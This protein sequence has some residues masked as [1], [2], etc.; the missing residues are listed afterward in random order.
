MID[1]SQSCQVDVWKAYVSSLW[2]KHQAKKEEVR[3]LRAQRRTHMPQFILSCAEQ[4]G[5]QKKKKV[6]NKN[7]PRRSLKFTHFRET[8][9]E[10]CQISC[11]GC[12]SEWS[13]LMVLSRGALE[14]GYISRLLFWWPHRKS[15]TIRA[16]F[17]ADPE[18]ST[19]LFSSHG[20]WLDEMMFS[21][22]SVAVM[23][24]FLLVSMESTLELTQWF[25]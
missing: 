22:C 14:R 4:P 11:H 21:R 19:Q 7:S 16:V 18:Y 10:S 2:L 25:S 9:K 12:K 24:G 8:N 6:D 1:Y 3:D 5:T 23:Q 13:E 15:L 20:P 17:Q